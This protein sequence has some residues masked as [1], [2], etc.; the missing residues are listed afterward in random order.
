MITEIEEAVAAYLR[1]RFTADGTLTAGTWE[2]KAATS[3]T[4]ASQNKAL[5]SIAAA[6][7]PQTWPS[8]LNVMVH[9]H[10]I[11]PAEPASLA[12]EAT[13]FEQAVARAFSSIDRPTVDAEIATKLHARLP[14]WE[15]GGIAPKGWQAGRETESFGPHFELELGLVRA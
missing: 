8:L 5:I 11:T 10:V 14:D 12:A 6:S 4:A 9:I 1:E 2:V 7:A 15:G 3:V 13:K